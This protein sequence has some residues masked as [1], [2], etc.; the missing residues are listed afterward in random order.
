M[1]STDLSLCWDTE[2]WAVDASEWGGGVCRTICD[3]ALVSEVG[4][5]S[6]RWRF[7]RGG[8]VS[9]RM[10]ARKSI[11]DAVFLEKG[12]AAGRAVD[13][14]ITKAKTDEEAR[15]IIEVAESEQGFVH[16]SGAI[17]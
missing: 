1:L 11:K 8:V 15:Q 12:D 9:L 17:S 7:K 6:E 5:F 10:L 16:P 13:M 3:A 4:S 14:Q 2:A